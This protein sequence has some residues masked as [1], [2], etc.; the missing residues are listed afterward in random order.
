MLDGNIHET[1]SNVQDAFGRVPSFIIGMAIAPLVR[2][3]TKVNVWHLIILPLIVYV[4]IHPFTGGNIPEVWL[5]V[6]PIVT[7]LT[8]IL[9]KMRTAGY[10]YRFATWL[11]V[12]SLESYL[13]NIYMPAITRY[14]LKPLRADFWILTGEYAEYAIIAVLGTLLAWGVSSISRPIVSMLSGN[15]SHT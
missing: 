6:I 8:I 5:L 10:A 11:G 14:T 3:K 13:A 4:P 2:R 7:L 9:E 15:N 1:L 12:I